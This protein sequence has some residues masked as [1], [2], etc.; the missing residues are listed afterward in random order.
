MKHAGV[1]PQQMLQS[2]IHTGHIR[3]ALDEQVNPSSVDLSLSGQCWRVEG[4]VQ[5][6]VNE[7]VEDSLACAGS[8]LHDLHQVMEVGVS[9]FARLRESVV[10]PHGVYG[11]CNP[12][13]ST[14]RNDVHV[15]VLADG[16]PRFDAVTPP[17]HSAT[18]WAAITPKS[19]PIIIPV[20][21]RIA[22]LRLFTVNTRFSELEL[23]IEM[24][25]TPLIFSTDGSVLKYSD[26]SITDADGSI[27]LT[28]SLPKGF[29]GY[30]CRR[31]SRVL[32]F[33]HRGYRW[34]DY[35][36]RLYSDGEMLRLRRGEFYVL[37]THEY[38]RVPPHLSCEAVDMDSRNGEF[39]SHY[40]GYIDAGWGYG[41]NGKGKGRPITL[42]VR[43][44]EDL[45]IRKG[46]AFAKIRFERMAEPPDEHYDQLGTSHYRSQNIAR[47]SKHFA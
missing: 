8:T 15:R 3:G 14:G 32:N 28:L 36:E 18:L 21:E 16:V 13:S 47:L 41:R 23:Q 44:Y 20:G 24:E 31:P 17:G 46:Q 2:F 9:Y 5:P 38:V 27:L 33:S 40:A 29:V 45:V 22:Q 43:P 4:I 1:L 25:R 10:L 35:F 6:R 42:E 12:K 26:L 30:R 11:Y 19:Y 39:R 7:R 34:H 37:S